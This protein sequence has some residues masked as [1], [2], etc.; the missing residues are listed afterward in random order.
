MIDVVAQWAHFKNDSVLFAY[1]ITI[2]LLWHPL[3]E[4]FFINESLCNPYKRC[5]HEAT[6]YDIVLI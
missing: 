1:N 5:N 3:L 2:A 6:V 4:Y